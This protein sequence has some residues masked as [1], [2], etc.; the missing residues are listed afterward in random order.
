MVLLPRYADTALSDALGFVTPCRSVTVADHQTAPFVTWVVNGATAAALAFAVLTSFASDFLQQVPFLRE[1]LTAFTL[2]WVLAILA[3][4]I[5]WAMR[6]VGR[7][8]H[9]R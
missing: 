2:C 8:R 7:G 4:A 5:P 1:P 3:Q 6:G 9:S